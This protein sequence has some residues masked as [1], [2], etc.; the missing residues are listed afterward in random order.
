MNGDS[1]Q[2]YYV[3]RAQIERERARLCTDSAAAIAHAAMAAEYERRARSAGRSSTGSAARAMQVE[4]T[5]Q[6][7]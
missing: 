5:A 6:A 3:R 7:R 2:L 1:D 4:P